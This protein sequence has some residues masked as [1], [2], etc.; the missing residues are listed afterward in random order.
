MFEPHETHRAQIKR[1]QSQSYDLKGQSDKKYEPTRETES[2]EVR[3]R[4]YCYIYINK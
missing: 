3:K 1:E 2:E 4:A